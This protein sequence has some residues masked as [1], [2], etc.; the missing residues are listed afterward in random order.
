MYNLYDTQNLF[1][2]DSDASS[3]G[4]ACIF[5]GEPGWGD[6]DNEVEEVNIANDIIKI[7]K[8]NW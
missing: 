4:V 3:K 8:G 5:E 7:I 6:T 2:G 1:Y